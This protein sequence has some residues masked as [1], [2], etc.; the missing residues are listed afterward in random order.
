MS[1]CTGNII[2]VSLEYFP[3]PLLF[4]IALNCYLF[5]GTIWKLKKR[6]ITLITL[7]LTELPVI[8]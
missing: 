4:S 1:H 5:L 3:F 2:S 6:P 8:K 7:Q